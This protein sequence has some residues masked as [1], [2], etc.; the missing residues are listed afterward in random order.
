MSA[1][2]NLNVVVVD[3]QIESRMR[4]RAMASAVHL[5]D[6]V[7]QVNSLKEALSRLN[8]DLD[9]DIVLIA[10]SFT[11]NEVTGFIKEALLTEFGSDAIFV[12]V[13]KSKAEVTKRSSANQEQLVGPDGYVFEPCSVETLTGLS[14]LIEP[15]RADRASNREML[16][17]QSV[18]QEIMTHLDHLAEVTRLE[19]DTSKAKE[20]LARKC[21]RLQK[22]NASAL[23]RYFEMAIMQFNTA[24][25]AIIVDGAMRYTGKNRRVQGKIENLLFQRIAKPVHQ[26]DRK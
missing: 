26:D 21:R 18:I 6:K 20:K 2:F 10:S 11:E 13:A 15:V 12:L 24:R 19:Y 23:D 3:A 5:F 1:V 16:S 14:E 17:I 7:H 22:L 8:T 9:V 4:L 25:P